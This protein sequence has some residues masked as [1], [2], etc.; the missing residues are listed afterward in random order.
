MVWDVGLE[1]AVT[2]QERALD[3]TTNRLKAL[4]QQRLQNIRMLGGPVEGTQCIII[5][6]RHSP[7]MER[8]TTVME[9]YLPSH[10]LSQAEEERSSRRSCL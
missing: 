10:E 5:V 3:N 6:E 1:T 9:A 7:F 8:Q 4:S 2:S